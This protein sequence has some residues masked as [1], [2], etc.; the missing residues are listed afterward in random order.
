MFQRNSSITPSHIVDDSDQQES[1]YVREVLITEIFPNKDIVNGQ[2][3]RLRTF[4]LAFYPTERGP[5]NYDVL[6]TSGISVGLTKM[7]Y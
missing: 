7:D 6:G 3:S 2:P 5:Y 1:N 4:D